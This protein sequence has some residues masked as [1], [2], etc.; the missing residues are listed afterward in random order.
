MRRGLQPWE[1]SP[2]PSI[3]FSLCPLFPSLAYSAR[4]GHLHLLPSRSRGLGPL[5]PWEIHP[6]ALS[7]LP[8]RRAATVGI[9]SQSSIPPLLLWSLPALFPSLV[10]SAR[11]GH[12]HLLPSRFRGLGTIITVGNSPGYFPGPPVSQLDPITRSFVPSFLLPPHLPHCAQYQQSNQQSMQESPTWTTP[13]P[14][15]SPHH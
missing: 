5:Q 1:S 2:R 8:Q 10:Y 4:Q 9:I 14:L 12:P 13:I 7:A 15:D 11:Q 3:P 6:V